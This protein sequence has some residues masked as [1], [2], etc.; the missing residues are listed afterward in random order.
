MILKIVSVLLLRKK[1]EFTFF[2]NIFMVIIIKN[3]SHFSVEAF[4][5][6]CLVKQHHK[7]SEKNNS[8]HILIKRIMNRYLPSRLFWKLESTQLEPMPYH[9]KRRDSLKY[10]TKFITAKQNIKYYKKKQENSFYV[11][12]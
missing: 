6:V 1:I 11:G 12:F 10:A 9:C 7:L 8:T 3:E 5:R 4:T 2:T